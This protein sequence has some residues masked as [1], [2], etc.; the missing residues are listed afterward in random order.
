MSLRSRKSDR[1]GLFSG[2]KAERAIIDIGSNTVRL[3]LYGASMR[4]P[5]VLLNE[6]VAA[7]LGRDIASSGEL[8]QEAVDLAL[9]GMERYALVLGDLGITDIEVVATAAVREA[10]NG[11]DFLGQLRALGFAPKVLSGVDEA[12]TSAWGVIGAF[13]KARG[14]VAD[15]GGGSLELVNVTGGAPS[16]AISLPIG[17]LRLPEMADDHAGLKKALEKK[18]RKADIVKTDG[19][20]YL[21]GGTFRAMAVFAMQRAGTPLTDPHGLSLP[22]DEAIKVAKEL[23]ATS[24]DDLQAEPRISSMRAGMLPDAAVLILTL[25]KHLKPDRVIISAWGLREGLL[26]SRLPDHARRQDPL[27]AGVAH[28]AAQRGAPPLLA[29]RVAGWTVGAVAKNVQ[30]SERLRLAATMLSL[31]AMQIEPNLRIRQGVEWALHKR[32]LAVDP[33]GRAMMAAAICANGNNLDLPD[34]LHAI[35]GDDALEEAICW[36]YA[37]RLCRRLGGRSRKSFESSQLLVEDGTLILRLLTSHAALFGVPNE[38]DLGLLADRLKLDA[39]MEVVEH[40]EDI[41]P[42]SGDNGIPIVG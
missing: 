8:A 41:T 18:L 30:G 29:T 3:V 42:V 36:G 21:V 24:S 19:S 35:A 34:E 14:M 4:A 12:C 40:L 17:T 33:V 10:A 26:F 5:K 6:K 32:W 39:R 23:A 38:K 1:E 20:L 25:L 9:R 31:A 13:P 22:Y 15:L 11:E 28:F 27:L 2:E 7:R 37:T 16:D